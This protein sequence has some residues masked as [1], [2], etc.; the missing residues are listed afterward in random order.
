MKKTLLYLISL[1][2]F[3]GLQEE[4]KAQTLSFLPRAGYSFDNSGRMVQTMASST[5]ESGWLNPTYGADL[6][7]TL[8]FLDDFVGLGIGLES[9]NDFHQKFTVM[10]SD[11]STLKQSRFIQAPAILFSVAANIPENK[12]PHL[13][14]P[15]GGISFGTAFPNIDEQ[16]KANLFRMFLQ[17]NYNFIVNQS[18]GEEEE[19][20]Y[21]IGCFFRSSFN[22]LTLTEGQ[23]FGSSLEIG[24][25]VAL[26]KK[27][28]E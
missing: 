5:V 8:P 15:I 20:A 10:Q 24:V 22:F 17:L 1:A 18:I 12:L 3:A 25:K 27:V 6:L 23:I 26:G 13:A 9:G 4:A 28:E 11:S 19:M 14:G 7:I 2:I 21:N 16:A